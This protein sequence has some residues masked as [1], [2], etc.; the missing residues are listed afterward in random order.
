MI[1]ASLENPSFSNPT[2]ASE[3]IPFSKEDSV[4]VK[5]I[6]AAR[7]TVLISLLFLGNAS[8]IVAKNRHV[9]N[10]TN[11]LI[12]NMVVPDLLISALA[13]PRELR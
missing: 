4:S 5:A 3:C 6:K 8:V 11:Y 7:Y 1:I 2:E 10:I 13:V 12:R 9:W